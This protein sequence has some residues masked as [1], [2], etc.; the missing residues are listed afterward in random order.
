VVGVALDAR[1][2]VAAHASQPDEADL[3]HD[4]APLLD[5]TYVV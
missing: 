2:H 3:R 4:G 5:G 1:D